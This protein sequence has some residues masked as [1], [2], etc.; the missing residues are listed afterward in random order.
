MYSM[1]SAA[2]NRLRLELQRDNLGSVPED[3][4]DGLGSLDIHVAIELG[5][6]PEDLQERYANQLHAISCPKAYS[7]A[8]AT[9]KGI[10]ICRN[11]QLSA[12]PEGVFNG[13]GSLERLTLKR[14]QI[15]ALP[16]GVFDGLDNLERLDLSGKPAKRAARRCI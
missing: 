4:F 1:A 7:T 11:N 14:N 9:W 10:W 13:L 16:E 5:S 2:W 8:P 3:V 6:P 12:L 15:G